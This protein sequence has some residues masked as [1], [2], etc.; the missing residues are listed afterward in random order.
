MEGQSAEASQFYAENERDII[1]VT[2][3]IKDTADDVEEQ[4]KF[5][6]VDEDAPKTN[7]K[8]SRRSVLKRM[9]K[10]FQNL[11]KKFCCVPTADS[12]LD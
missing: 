5:V 1:D 6:D 3:E 12:V 4:K 9:R 11:K 7:V 10:F 8:K 2:E